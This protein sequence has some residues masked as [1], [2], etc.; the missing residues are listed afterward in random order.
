MLHGFPDE[1]LDFFSYIFT[2]T[3]F[4]KV[5]DMRKFLLLTVPLAALSACA[6]GP[7]LQSR[8]ASFTGASE[9][10]LVEQLGVPDKQV[11]VDGLQY[12]AYDHR[13]IDFDPGFAGPFYGPGFY[14]GPFYGGGFIGPGPFFDAGIPSR[15]SEVACETTFTLRD[16]KVIGFTLRGDDCS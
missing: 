3:V 16:D 14:G 4:L 1:K 8:M 2:T 11:T 9:K 10:T 13:D 6:T 5:I 12:L 7:S 15:V